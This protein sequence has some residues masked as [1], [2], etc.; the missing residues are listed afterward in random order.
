MAKPARRLWPDTRL[1]RTRRPPSGRERSRIEGRPARARRP[2]AQRGDD[3]AVRRARQALAAVNSPE[4]LSALGTF[5]S[6][7]RPLRRPHRAGIRRSGDHH[8]LVQHAQRAERA[9]AYRAEH[10]G[11]RADRPAE[12]RRQLVPR[13][14]AISPVTSRPSPWPRRA[15][16]RAPW[17]RRPR[18]WSPLRRSSSRRSSDGA[19]L[20]SAAAGL[21]LAAAGLRLAALVRRP[22]LGDLLACECQAICVR[23]AAPARRHRASL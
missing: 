4:G 12:L 15:R 5:A 8:G 21:R 9:F 7:R 1:G 18:P 22:P 13:S 3:L 14:C 11:E 2:S 16:R 10:S 6:F 23:C 20:M 17:P 19:G